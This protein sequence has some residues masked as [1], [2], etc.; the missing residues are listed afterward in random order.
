MSLRL[1]Q[2]YVEESIAALFDYG[3]FSFNDVRFVAHR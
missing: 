1:L 3:S 2:F